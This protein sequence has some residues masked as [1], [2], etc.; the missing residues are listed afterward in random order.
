MRVE[1]VTS[2]A[3]LS[4]HLHQQVLSQQ[5]RGAIELETLT[6]QGQTGTFFFYCREMDCWWWLV[7]KSTA[8][9][10][11]SFHLSPFTS[12]LS[13]ACLYSYVAPLTSARLLSSIFSKHDF[14]QFLLLDF[15]TCLLL[16]AELLLSTNS[17][18]FSVYN[19]L[20]LLLKAQYVLT[21]WIIDCLGWCWPA[22]LVFKHATLLV[23]VSFKAYFTSLKFLLLSRQVIMRRSW[24]WAGRRNSSVR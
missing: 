10:S 20:N 7:E 1:R 18:Y 2:T 6:S 22:V 4:Q 12:Y 8:G 3:A 23:H 9:Q 21:V 24:W 14:P 15:Q 17:K 16:S 5:D 11:Y 19:M 13:L